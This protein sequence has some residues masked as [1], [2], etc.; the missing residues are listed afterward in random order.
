MGRV[1]RC[2]SRV[3][4]SR[5]AH[6][7]LHAHKHDAP[8]GI[9]LAEAA[10]AFEPDEGW[11]PCERSHVSCAER[12]AQDVGRRQACDGRAR[13]RARQD[14]HAVWASSGSAVCRRAGRQG[15]GT[16]IVHAIAAI[17]A[18]VSQLPCPTIVSF[19]G[20]R[21]APPCSRPFAYS[22]CLFGMGSCR[23]HAH[24]LSPVSSRETPRFSLS[25]P[26]P[27]CFALEQDIPTR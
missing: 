15:V 20:R 11:A 6:S 27:V 19:H 18:E 10:C 1:R 21:R 4:S 12:R 8:R 9:Q 26:T 22:E 25:I 7:T 13:A 3:A 5:G 17:D 14:E 24:L 23:R 16:V 2:I